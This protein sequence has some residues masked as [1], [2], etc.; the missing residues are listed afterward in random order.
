M[1]K[2]LVILLLFFPVHGAWGLTLFCQ[3]PTSV[4]FKVEID[5]ENSLILNFRKKNWPAK[6]DEYNI[7]WIAGKEYFTL[8]RTTGKLVMI[9]YTSP[10]IDGE[11]VCDTKKPKKKF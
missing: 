2:L 10:D 6:I 5:F 1:K 8:N 7:S 3:S 9:S 4:L 11:Y